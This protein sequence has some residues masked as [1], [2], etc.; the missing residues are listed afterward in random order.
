MS[1]RVTPN[2]LFELELL[3]TTERMQMGTFHSTFVPLKQIINETKENFTILKKMEN[4]F[5]DKET[6]LAYFWC[7]STLYFQFYAYNIKE[8]NYN[9]EIQYLIERI[10]SCILKC[11]DFDIKIKSDWAEWQFINNGLHKEFPIEKTEWCE[12]RLKAFKSFSQTGQCKKDYFP[13]LLYILMEKSES[14]DIICTTRRQTNISWLSVYCAYINN[15]DEFYMN[16]NNYILNHFYFYCMYSRPEER[17]LFTNSWRIRGL[18]E[19]SRTHFHDIENNI[20]P[21]A[22]DIDTVCALLHFETLFRGKSQD[23]EYL[24][25]Y[26]LG[27][28]APDTQIVESKSLSLLF[29]GI[30]KVNPKELSKHPG[31]VFCMYWTIRYMKYNDF[32]NLFIGKVESNFINEVEEKEINEILS[33]GGTLTSKND[34]NEKEYSDILQMIFFFLLYELTNK[35]STEID[36]K[37]EKDEKDEAIKELIDNIKE[38]KWYKS[39][40]QLKIFN[41]LA[42]KIGIKIPLSKISFNEKSNNKSNFS[43]TEVAINL[44]YNITH[45]CRFESQNYLTA[46]INFIRE[47]QKNDLPVSI[48]KSSKDLSDSNIRLY[49]D[50]QKKLRNTIDCGFII[51]E[52]SQNLNPFENLIITRDITCKI[53]N[54]TDNKYFSN[55]KGIED[56]R[57]MYKNLF[58]TKYLYLERNMQTHYSEFSPLESLLQEQNYDDLL[59]CLYDAEKF[60]EQKS[61]NLS[62]LIES[63]NNDYDDFDFIDKQI[64]YHQFLINQ[65]QKYRIAI[66][67]IINIELNRKGELFDEYGELI[68][69]NKA[70]KR[71]NNKLYYC[72][73]FPEE[74][75]CELKE[76]LGTLFCSNNIFNKKYITSD[77]KQYEILNDNFFDIYGFKIAIYLIKVTIEI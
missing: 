69:P 73:K 43:K 70:I 20:L 21:T 63:H 28:F 48:L 55:R 13:F 11:E 22:F 5:D 67:N 61:A 46:E 34:F 36:E 76:F 51:K 32:K 8:T 2:D 7:V 71:R 74:F 19:S 23:I 30:M 9:E 18:S 75:I 10:I 29:K 49:E 62:V 24:I 59:K 58:N 72:D 44:I 14:I 47:Q 60:L 77:K 66:E 50:N 42:L 56:Y 53:F 37:D 65:C 52:F 35:N 39:E 31:I 45:F 16:I 68:I 25:F 26:C 3:E 17:E 27:Y 33:K 15:E 38:K 41:Q 4:Y 12:K 57:G 64:D 54:E 6:F 1:T 40:Y